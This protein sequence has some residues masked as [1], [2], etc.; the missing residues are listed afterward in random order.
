MTE[1]NIEPKKRSGWGWIVVLLILLVIG[2]LLYKYMFEVQEGNP[3]TTGTPTTG[4]VLPVAPV[5]FTT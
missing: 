5:F 2:W 4:M 3:E 1:I